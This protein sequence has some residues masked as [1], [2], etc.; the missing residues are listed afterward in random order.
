MVFGSR[1]RELRQQ[2][3]YTQAELGEKLGLSQFT[4]SN[5]EQSSRQ[6]PLEIL[7]RLADILGTS[8][9]YLLG[10]VD[11]NNPSDPMTQVL[12]HAR[13]HHFG[14]R[15]AQ[16]RAVRRLSPAQCALLVH[17]DPEQWEQWEQGTTFPTLADLLL[18]ADT[19]HVSL[20]W[21]LDR[22]TNLFPRDDSITIEEWHRLRTSVATME[23]LWRRR[24]S[25]AEWDAA[26][27]WVTGATDHPE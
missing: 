27:R 26:R 4:I 7:V 2:H 16:V 25:Q 12:P 20:D 24:V 9:D 17:V 21:L 18:V 11:V 1:M 10:R 14:E 22:P 23:E 3:G 19:L 8:T 6:P 13:W 5:Y 15:L